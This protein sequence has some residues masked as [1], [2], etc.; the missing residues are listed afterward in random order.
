MCKKKNTD[1]ARPSRWAAILSPWL[2]LPELQN[3]HFCSN[4]EEIHA[5]AQ[6]FRLHLH[7][8]FCAINMTHRLCVQN[9]KKLYKEKEAKKYNGKTRNRERSSAAIVFG[10]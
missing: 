4:L 8:V 7:L 5:T 6:L 2:T 1:T 10:G 3:D 9:K